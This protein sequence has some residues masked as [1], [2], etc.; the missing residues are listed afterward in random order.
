VEKD[1]VDISRPMHV[2]VLLLQSDPG[3]RK[4]KTKKEEKEI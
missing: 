1:A 3:I 4:K 2:S